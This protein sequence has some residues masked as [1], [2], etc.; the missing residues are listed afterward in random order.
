MLFYAILM[1]MLNNAITVES[2]TINDVAVDTTNQE[3]DNGSPTSVFWWKTDSQNIDTF[4]KLY[5]GLLV[6]ISLKDIV[7]NDTQLSDATLNDQVVIYVTNE[8]EFSVILMIINKRRVKPIRV[9][10]VIM[11]TID[12]INIRMKEFTKTAWDNDVADIIIISTNLKNEIVLNTFIPYSDG[13][14]GDYTP[15]ALSANQPKLFSNKFHNFHK[16]PIRMRAFILPPYVM[17]EKRS[18]SIKTVRGFDADVMKFILEQ[19]NATIIVISDD[20]INN[21]IFNF[22]N[23]SLS[24]NLGD[25]TNNLADVA[26][27]P[28]I[29]NNRRY[30]VAQ[31]FYACYNIPVIWCAPRQREIYAWAKVILPFLSRISPLI[32]LSFVAFWASIK[33]I[34]RFGKFKKETKGLLLASFALYMGQGVT[35]E[36]QHWLNNVVFMMWIWYCTIMR[37]V[38]QGDLID[39]LHNVILEPPLRTL[40]DALQALDEVVGLSVAVDL[41]DNMSIER[42][43]K[44]VQNKEIPYYLKRISH[45]ERILLAVNKILVSY[46]KYKVQILEEN[47]STFKVYFFVRP[48]WG[49]FEEL[50]RTMIR[51]TEVG[52]QWQIYQVYINEWLRSG[53]R[54]YYTEEKSTALNMAILISCFYGLIALYVV[55]FLVFCFEILWFKISKKPF[56]DIVR[57]DRVY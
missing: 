13:H 48:R 16:C 45:G 1:L 17:H 46:S 3:F 49:A 23:V 14:C 7:Y 8:N 42:R 11:E 38:Y 33:L 47:V 21:T 30:A 12:D 24:E 32:F 29:I 5:E 28:F 40:N 53:G 55:C 6:T 57:D 56:A 9:I 2:K 37:I 35:F 54:D 26:V 19:M 34:Q 36:T 50:H 15:V 25:L 44:P 22:A 10:L 18:D 4:T 20:K 41:Y 31:A 27:P 51:I 43:F 39:G 52:F